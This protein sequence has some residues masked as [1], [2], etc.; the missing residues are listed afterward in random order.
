MVQ[1]AIKLKKI[2]IQISYIIENTAESVVLRNFA[3][4]LHYFKKGP[5]KGLFL[6]AVL[7]HYF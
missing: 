6:H 3:A 2:K 1:N 4:Q 7:L 5:M